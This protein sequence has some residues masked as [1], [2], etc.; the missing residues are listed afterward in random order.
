VRVST[1]ANGNGTHPN[2]TRKPIR[3]AKD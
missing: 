1:P 3:A 2:P